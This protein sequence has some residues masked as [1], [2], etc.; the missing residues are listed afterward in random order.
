MSTTHFISSLFQSK[1]KCVNPYFADD[2]V[3]W[4][5]EIL[6]KYSNKKARTKKWRNGKSKNAILILKVIKTKCWLQEIA[7]KNPLLLLKRDES[8]RNLW[9]KKHMTSVW[10]CPGIVPVC[11]SALRLTQVFKVERWQHLHLNVG[12]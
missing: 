8:S 5:R 7:A 9:K 1:K 2:K 11:D 10:G 6:L 12:K 4:R 3:K